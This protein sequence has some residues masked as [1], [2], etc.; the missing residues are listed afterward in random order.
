M[1]NREDSALPAW[2]TK[3]VITIIITVLSVAATI[4]IV[5]KLS[6]LISWILIS[7]FLSFALEPVV[8]KIT[9]SGMSRGPA[10]F[11]VLFG[12]VGIVILAFGT[13][14]PLI[15][16]QTTQFIRQSP[17]WLDNL[18]GR[19]NGTFDTQITQQTIIDELSS[20]NS[21]LSGYAS[22]IAG[23]LLGFGKQ[24]FLGIM[25]VLA[26]ILFT[27]YFVADAPHLRRVI[28]SLLPPR[29]QK[30]VLSTWE[31][32]IDKTGGFIFSRGIL[33]L[34]SA[35]FTFIILTILGVPF[36]LPLALWMGIVSQFLPVIGTYIAA[37]IPLFVALINNPWDALIL[38]IFIIIYQQLENYIFGPKITAHTMELHPAIAFG[39]AIAGASIAGVF[40]ALLALP[41]AAILQE[42]LKVYFKRHEVVESKMI[43]KKIIKG[44]KKKVLT[45]TKA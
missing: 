6:G 34:L 17:I 44:K 43:A 20:A 19:I 4:F 9:K 23:N 30:I 22:N 28:C 36:A 12:F 21:F 11:L 14:I 10:T 29:H 39:A 26:I 25:Q 38:L 13:M 2:A 32:A 27:Y 40:G 45:K 31:I 24:V 37:S 42:S 16:D 18:I 33:G 5:F 7:L 8:N 3:L 15:I 41:I 1:A 35:I